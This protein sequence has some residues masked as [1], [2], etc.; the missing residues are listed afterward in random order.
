MDVL[1][2]K[3]KIMCGIVSMK[4][5]KMIAKKVGCEV[6]IDIEE[7]SIKEEGDE[8]VAH[9]SA[10]GSIPKAKLSELLKLWIM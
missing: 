4:L 5:K 1:N 7:I 8:Y 3:S 2:I 10:T 9:I 6:A